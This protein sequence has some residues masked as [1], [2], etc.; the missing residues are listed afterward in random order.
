MT[1]GSENE[2][3]NAFFKHFSGWPLDREMTGNFFV[4]REFF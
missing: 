4:D 3:V 2:K 1:F